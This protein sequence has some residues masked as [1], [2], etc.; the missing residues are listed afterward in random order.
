MTKGDASACRTAA[1]LVRLDRSVGREEVE[2][3][4]RVDIV[5][6][7]GRDGMGWEMGR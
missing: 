5:G 7:V 4:V 1:W 2:V 3:G 6:F